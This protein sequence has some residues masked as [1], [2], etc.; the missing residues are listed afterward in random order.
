MARKWH[1]RSFL[2]SSGDAIQ[3]DFS[4]E[5]ESRIFLA[6]S[7]HAAKHLSRSYFTENVPIE[8]HFHGIGHIDFSTNIEHLDLLAIQQFLFPNQSFLIF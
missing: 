6:R 7:A 2:S 1:T 4:Y 5:D 3:G 8:V